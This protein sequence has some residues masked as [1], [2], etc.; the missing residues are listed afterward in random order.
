MPE[1]FAK[2]LFRNPKTDATINTENFTG[3]DS[4]G[5]VISGGLNAENLK[6]QGFNALN[7]KLVN[8]GELFS[9]G[10]GFQ[11][12]VQRPKGFGVKP[13]A[14]EAAKIVFTNPKTGD[15]TSVD[16]TDH[17]QMQKLTREGQVTESTDFVSDT[18]PDIIS[19]D[20][21]FEEARGLDTA[22]AEA[23]GL[24]TAEQAVIKEQTDALI[25]G[26]TADFEASKEAALKAQEADKSTEK[27]IQFR[28]GQA[29]TAFGIEQTKTRDLQRKA[30]L[31]SLL[32]QKQ[33]LISKAQRASRDDNIKLLKEY[34]TQI[35][36]LDTKYFDRQRE[37]R[38]DQIQEFIDLSQEERLG[39]RLGFDI[40]KFN[41]G[42]A[43]L[44]RNQ[45]LVAEKFDY[46]VEKDDRERTLKNITRMANSG[47]SIDGLTD[48]EIMKL[49]YEAGLEFGTFEAFYSS[50]EDE[51]AKGEIIDDLKIEK[52][53][54]DIANVRSTI[55]KRETSG[56]GDS[57]DDKDIQKFREAVAEMIIEL[58]KEDGGVVWSTAFDNIKARFPEASNDAINGALGGGI[59][60]SNG[61]F[62]T[63]G[64]FGRAKE[65]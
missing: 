15:T 61:E 9:D 21:V 20:K 12:F 2:G 41:I 44:N 58:D 7:S 6:T 25:Q 23:R 46:Q 64:A 50:L 48:E 57:G 19:G 11:K 39:A 42:E 63:S 55:N 14:P 16:P 43:R 49:E 38:Q 27:A 36:D 62:D 30:E 56:S 53:M 59:P 22:V 26:I 13:T 45:A 51:K 8:G 52:A 10:T 18:T 33:D 60:F 5:N 65:K 34:M 4:L 24:L 29:G 3:R 32:S 40:D 1:N 37:Q 54:V 31:N 17:T 28:T 47:I 35:E